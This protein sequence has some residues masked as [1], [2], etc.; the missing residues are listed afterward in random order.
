MVSQCKSCGS[1]RSLELDAE[2]C[3]HF[4]GPGGL[5]KQPIFAFAKVLVCPDCGSVQSNLSE[6][7]L[8]QVRE[9][10]REAEGAHE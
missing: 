3:L 8:A 4:G 5:N 7:E 9:S 1:T 10:V 6:K 2:V